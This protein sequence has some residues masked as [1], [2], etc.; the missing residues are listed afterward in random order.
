[1]K[2]CTEHT[3]VTDVDPL[4]LC[5][6][7]CCSIPVSSG[8][9]HYSIPNIYSVLLKLGRMIPLHSEERHWFSDS[10]LTLSLQEI[11]STDGPVTA[12][13]GETCALH[14]HCLSSSDLSVSRLKDPC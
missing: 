9:S 3:P 12:L 7:K 1:M 8:A 14:V 6:P 10:G 2:I 5:F 11:L 4:Q 13:N